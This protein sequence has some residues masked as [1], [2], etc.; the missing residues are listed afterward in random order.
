MK[1]HEKLCQKC[2]DCKTKC[3]NCKILITF[4][5]LEDHQCDLNDSSNSSQDSLMRAFV[6]RDRIIFNPELMPVDQQ[7]QVHRNFCFG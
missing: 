2:P 6:P 3:S 7:V 5:E 1:D 4:G